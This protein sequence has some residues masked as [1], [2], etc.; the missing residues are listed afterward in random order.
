MGVLH[1]GS[2]P[3]DTMYLRQRAENDIY[4]TSRVNSLDIFTCGVQTVVIV[5][6]A[7]RTA[8]FL[9]T[10]GFRKSLGVDRC[11]LNWVTTL[12]WKSQH[13][14]H[15]SSRSKAIPTNPTR[16]RTILSQ[17]FPGELSPP[18]MLTVPHTPFWCIWLHRATK[19]LSKL[20]LVVCWTFFYQ[21]YSI[22][23]LGLIAYVCEPLRQENSS[24]S[25]K[26]N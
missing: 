15:W 14:L 4:L 9:V 21:W 12:H 20:L 18:E 19:Y 8:D 25:V 17:T 2:F 6:L 22:L 11:S 23:S 1:M 7:I 16:N 5:L 3:T 24:P 26:L 10:M 13:R